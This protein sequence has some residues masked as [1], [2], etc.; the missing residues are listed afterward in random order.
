[1]Q[2]GHSRRIGKNSF[3]LEHLCHFLP[4]SSVPEKKNR[5][6][7]CFPLFI[8]SGKEKKVLAV[9]ERKGFFRERPVK[10]FEENKSAAFPPI[11]ANSHEQ[12]LIHSRRCYV[13]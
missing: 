3:V 11:A 5:S 1:M 12:G 4:V 7:T 13:S 6:D 9:S 2:K 10:R 8:V